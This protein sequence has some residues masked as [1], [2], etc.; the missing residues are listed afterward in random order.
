MDPISQAT[1]GALAAQ[2]AFDPKKARA[3]ALVGCVAGIAPDADVFISSSTDSLLFLE[4]HRQFTHALLFI[5]VGAAIVALATHWLVRRRLRPAETYLACLLAYATHGL[6]DACTS[7]GTQLFWPLADARV[8]WN[9]V[10][11][12]DPMF[13]LP[14]LVL[15]IAAAVWRRRGLAWLAALW[16]VAYLLFGVV[17]SQ[18][19]EAG[20]AALAS[21]RGHAPARLTAKP[22]FG[23]LLLWK[24]V[25]RHGGRY[26]VDAA[27]AGAT[28]AVC[29]G[30]SVPVLDL[31]R[32]LPW[33]AADSQQARDVERFRWFSADY[34]AIDPQAAG[35]VIDIRYS[36]VPNQIAPLWGIELTPGAPPTEHARFVADR[37]ASPEANA[38][39]AELLAGAGCAA[40]KLAAGHPP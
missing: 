36:V 16:G 26:Y 29:P 6:L 27:R 25:Y 23:N 40:P 15:A 12:V 11:V 39:Y 2:C 20:G 17:Q 22:G 28:V 33:L 21:A 4:Y 18:R 7:Y 3:A 9:N 32:D 1:V 8:A 35:R 13:T 14:V 30:A 37:R 38:A 31:P 19:A 34:V 5:P 24:T 10:S